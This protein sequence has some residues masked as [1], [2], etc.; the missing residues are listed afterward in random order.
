M[1]RPRPTDELLT[2]TKL[3]NTILLLTC[4]DWNSQEGVYENRL[5]VRA[6]RE[7]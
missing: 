6:S 1:N 3:P 5:L 7:Q 2:M 4:A